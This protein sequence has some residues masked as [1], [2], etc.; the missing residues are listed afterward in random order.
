MSTA[1]LS[2]TS[3]G[4]NLPGLSLARLPASLF[5]LTSHIVGVGLFADVALQ[6]HVYGALSKIGYNSVSFFIVL[7]GFV[8]TWTSQGTSVG[9]RRFM[10][11][12]VVKV[13]PVHLVAWVICVG[14]Y[15]ATT[16]P[17]G[18]I[19]ANL[20]LVQAWVPDHTVYFAVNNPA[21]TLSVEICFYL[22]FPL[23]YRLLVRR[24]TGTLRVLVV[25]L[26]AAV[27]ALPFVLSLFP[28]GATFSSPGMN[29]HGRP[30][31]ISE[32]KFWLVY[33]CPAA[34]IAESVLGM[35]V[36]L[37]LKRGAWPRIP[38]WT[39]LLVL[40]PEV[41]VATEH[42][43]FIFA[44]SAVTI[45][46][47]VLLVGTVGAGD[48]RRPAGRPAP[49]LSRF[50]RFTFGVYMYQWPLLWMWYLHRQGHGYSGVEAVIVYA[51]IVALT[52]AATYLSY[53]LVEKPLDQRW[54]R[55]N[56]GSRTVRVGGGTLAP[57]GASAERPVSEAPAEPVLHQG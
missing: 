4:G 56:A 5:I 43:H 38:R 35:L 53:Q 21:W 52:L 3:R 48:L 31:A 1:Q 57:A 24:S 11:R 49:A 19:L 37:L 12:R 8:L 25:L 15:A 17:L 55:R 27:V 50:G 32:W 7:S 46:G 26:T 28:D 42:A 20:F 51:G 13:I 40:V 39:A 16:F 41:Y 47:V 23:L 44:T 10:S 33:I 54:R 6:S 29:Y 36:A 45:T 2:G 22:V 30:E 14:L 9:W 18:T 34:R